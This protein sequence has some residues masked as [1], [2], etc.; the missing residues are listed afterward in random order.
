MRSFTTPA[1]HGGDNEA[2][3]QSGPDEET[4][5][6]SG[7]K[8]VRFVEPSR[9]AISSGEQMPV[10]DGADALGKGL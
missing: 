3:A 2:G 6:F 5:T 10:R 9:V 7:S 4:S 8:A 1:R